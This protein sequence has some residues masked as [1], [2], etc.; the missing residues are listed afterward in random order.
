MVNKHLGKP[1]VMRAYFFRKLPDTKRTKAQRREQVEFYTDSSKYFDEPKIV[2]LPVGLRIP[3]ND[4]TFVDK[5][6]LKKWQRDNDELDNLMQR[7]KHNPIIL[8]KNV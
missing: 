1:K 7:G 6:Q 3:T 5:K 8:K 4:W 2:E